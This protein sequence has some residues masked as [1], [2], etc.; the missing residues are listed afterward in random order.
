MTVFS[1]SSSDAGDCMIGKYPTVIFSGLT[2]LAIL[3]N[4]VQDGS[5]F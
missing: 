3:V 2:V 4:N 1:V 5:G